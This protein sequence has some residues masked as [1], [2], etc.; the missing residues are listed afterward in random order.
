MK[1]GQ[2]ERTKQKNYGKNYKNNGKEERKRR[3]KICLKRGTK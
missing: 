2:E 1:G 3:N